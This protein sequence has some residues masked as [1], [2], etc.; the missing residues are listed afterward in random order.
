[1][2]KSLWADLGEKR[3]FQNGL[4][5]E[6]EKLN[7]LEWG[8]ELGGLSSGIERTRAKIWNRGSW[9]WG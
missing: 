6:M 7:I 4:V 5:S 2:E 1:M 9:D 3:I 8:L